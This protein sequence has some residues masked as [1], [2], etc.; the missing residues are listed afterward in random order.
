MARL[1]EAMPKT[2][3][4]TGH[5][6]GAGYPPDVFRK[7]GDLLQALVIVEHTFAVGGPAGVPAGLLRDL[8]IITAGLAG[9]TWLDA[10]ADQAAAFTALYVTRRPPPLAEL[11]QILAGLLSAR[12]G[13][14]PATAAA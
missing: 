13:L 9:R 1:P 2:L 14:P 8:V 12:F 3:R 10:N 11:D 6:R 5:V 4:A 7:A